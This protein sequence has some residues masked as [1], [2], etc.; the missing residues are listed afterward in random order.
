MKTNKP[1]FTLLLLGCFS[2]LFSCD[3]DY[4]YDT[5]IRIENASQ[6][7]IEIIVEKPSSEFLTGSITVKSGTT[8][9]TKHSIDGG[10][11]LPNPVDAQINFDDGTTITHHWADG[12]T[13]HNFCSTTAFEKKILGKRSVEYI[14]VFTDEDY[15]YAKK[16]AD[17]TE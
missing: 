10:N 12:D 15:E 7:D 13:Y 2:M 9:I 3:I 1:I 11:G 17:K 5:E 14:F 4:L 16:H 6:H 8:F